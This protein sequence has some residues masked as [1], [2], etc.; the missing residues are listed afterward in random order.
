MICNDASAGL[1]RAV[2]GAIC[3]YRHTLPVVV[4]T[5]SVANAV[6]HASIGA[7]KVSGTW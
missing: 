1:L 5:V 7:G 4:L 3:A 2:G 6:I